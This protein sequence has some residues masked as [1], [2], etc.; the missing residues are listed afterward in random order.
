MKNKGKSIKKRLAIFGLIVVLF[1]MVGTVLINLNKTAIDKVQEN[2]RQEQAKATAQY[3]EAMAREEYL[4]NC[5]N[6]PTKDGEKLRQF[7]VC[8]WEGVVDA[9]GLQAMY[10][11]Y[12]Y[13]NKNGDYSA[14]FVAVTSDCANKVNL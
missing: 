10:D 4:N 5:T 11:E 6:D 14:D 7:C 9:N 13:Y 8:T 1:L 2:Q 3:E 12:E